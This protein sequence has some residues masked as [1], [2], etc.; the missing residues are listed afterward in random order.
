MMCASSVS[1]YLP[2][3]SFW[4]KSAMGSSDPM[5]RPACTARQ[6]SHRHQRTCRQL[7]QAGRWAGGRGRGRG[8]QGRAGQGRA[9]QGR[10]GTYRHILVFLLVEGKRVAVLGVGLFSAVPP[11]S[12]ASSA[13]ETHDTTA[14]RPRLP[15]CARRPSAAP[16][17]C[18][19]ALL[20]RAHF[21]GT[22][23][24]GRG[25]QRGTARA[26]TRPAGG[27]RLLAEL[28]L[29]RRASASCAVM[30]V[31][32]SNSTSGNTSKLMKDRTPENTSSPLHS[33]RAA[34][35]ERA[36]RVSRPSGRG[37]HACK[38]AQPHRSALGPLATCYPACGAHAGKTQAQR[39]PSRQHYLNKWSLSLKGLP[40]MR[41]HARST[42]SCQAAA[43]LSDDSWSRA[44]RAT[45]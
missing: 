34:S 32:T 2:D 6:T 9:G 37:R 10:V 39:G 41:M 14:T 43:S 30:P 3:S 36:H 28:V 7:V 15:L 8:R 13:C 5:C 17:L 20:H 27:R 40:R 45:L 25:R 35:S 18:P 38:R 1:G 11:C 21:H 23:R 12:L 22:T 4:L 33:K 26:G 24:S 44:R 16:T 42:L 19:Y 29:L 31:D